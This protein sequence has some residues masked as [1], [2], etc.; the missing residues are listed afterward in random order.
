MIKAVIFDVGGVLKVESDQDI[1]RD[2]QET[3]GISPENFAVPW[4][5]LTDQLGRGVID[6]S[7]FWKELHTL[8]GAT[9]AV[10]E[11]SLLMRRYRTTYQLN[12]DMLALVRRLQSA[13]Y[14]TA[15]LSNTISVHADFN[16]AR[17]VFEGFDAIVLSHKVGLRKPSPEIFAHTLQRLGVAPAEAVFIDD[18]EANVHGAEATGM[19]GI[20]FTN[21]RKLEQEL[22]QLGVSF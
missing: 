15:I 8:A 3:L 21:A 17:G 6:E 20:L 1:R 14:K 12:E 13:G 5:K 16:R 7:T 10:P 22:T 11:E 2:V 19:H 18:I 4:E 9:N